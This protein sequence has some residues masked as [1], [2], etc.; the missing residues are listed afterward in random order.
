M[1]CEKLGVEVEETWDATDGLSYRIVDS[2]NVMCYTRSGEFISQ[3]HHNWSKILNSEIEPEWR[4]KMGD[5][6]YYPSIDM[7]KT[8]DKFCRG[9]WFGDVVDDYRLMN[10][11]VYKDQ[12]G[13]I[14]AYD[15]MIDSLRRG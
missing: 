2:E 11:L 1:I 5:Y 6:Y 3:G 13:A 4:P 10:N 12:K 8:S 15:K 9:T 14:E 7:N